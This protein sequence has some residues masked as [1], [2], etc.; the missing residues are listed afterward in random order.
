MRSNMNEWS[1]MGRVPATSQMLQ[2]FANPTSGHFKRLICSESLSG[3][4]HSDRKQ[5]DVTV[6][7]MLHREIHE[8]VAANGE[9]NRYYQ[10]QHMHQIQALHN[11]LQMLRSS[12]YLWISVSLYH[13]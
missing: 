3:R 8:T 12:S 4:V 6:Q 11:H 9:I 10:F 1:F 5:T 13:C 7:H 2:L